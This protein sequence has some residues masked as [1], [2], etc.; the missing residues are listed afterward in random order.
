VQLTDHPPGDLDCLVEFTGSM[1]VIAGLNELVDVPLAGL[2]E[3]FYSPAPVLSRFAM[4]YLDRLRVQPGQPSGGPTVHEPKH[5][6]VGSV[7]WGQQPGRLG[8]L[9]R[10]H[11][12]V[13]SFHRRARL[14]LDVRLVL[15]QLLG[16]Q[17]GLVG[18]LR[19]AA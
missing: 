11:P 15:G 4:R 2:R 16:G 17:A 9:H 12:P 19:V 8:C 6:P 7:H 18:G 10:R 5:L 14:S 13:R 3:Y 1:M